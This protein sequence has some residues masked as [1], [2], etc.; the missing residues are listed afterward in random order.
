[1]PATPASLTVTPAVGPSLALTPLAPTRAVGEAVQFRVTGTFGDGTT[2]DLTQTVTW[3]SSNPAVATVT[4]PGG[5]AMAASPGVATI[6]AVHPAG[7]TVS[8]TLT[9]AMLAPTL[10]SLIPNR[11]PAGMAVNLFGTHIGATSEVR[12][13]GV[14]ATF[15]VPSITQVTATVPAGA[16]TGPVT[17]TT[18]SGTAASA[19][20]FT[21]TVPPTVAITNPVEGATVAGA[22]VQ[23]RG[24]V[25]SDTLEVGV[26]VNGLV[27]QVN[28]GA[29]V[30]TVPLQ[31]GANVLTATATDATGAQATASIT[32]TATE[33]PA[34]LLVLRAVPDSGVAPL[35]VR[36][37]VTNL[38]GRP[39]VQY[40]LDANG[41][42]T[43]GAPM[44][45][46]DGVQ[47]TYTTPGLVHPVLRAT[48]DQGTP[49]IAG[50]TANVLDSAAADA[51]FQA[52]WRGVKDA[53]RQ[54]DIPHALEEVFSRSRS[55]YQA[56]FQAVLPDLAGVD[57]IL[58]NLRLI[59]IRGAEAIFE[60][61]RTDD[62]VTKSF[63]VRFRR[64]EDG[65]WRLWMF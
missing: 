44:A 27:A 7:P 26:A 60:M 59:E 45:T 58:T 52:R 4:S 39:L 3:T 53:L 33:A 38:T 37:Q 65:I 19:D 1:M 62:G 64:D 30:V 42:G 28:S 32:V 23:V 35:T 51:V 41:T 20:N 46:L 43:F 36:W 31:V 25:A 48:D 29:W 24:T 13:N 50:T 11:G 18:P 2:Q 5:L 12:F 9:A 61:L 15:T 34:A 10:D 6:T 22:S 49:H 17:V 14:P 21:V 55:R 56:I 16:T 47:T 63:E 57:S 40:E 8:T 54:A